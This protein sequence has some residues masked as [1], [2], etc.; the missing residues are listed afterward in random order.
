MIDF[1]SYSWIATLLVT[2]TATFLLLSVDWRWNSLVLAAQYVGVLFLVA[3]HWPLAMAVTKLVAGWM[4]VAVLGMATVTIPDNQV[5]LTSGRITVAPP[6]NLTLNPLL[7]LFG[8]KSFYIFTCSMV[9]I[10]IVSQAPHFAVWIP[11]IQPEQTWSGLV[12]I[13][14]G[15]LKTGFTDRPFPTIIGLLSALSGFEVLYANIQNSLLMA[16]LLSGVT[17]VLALV[18]AYLLIS[19]QMETTS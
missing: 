11:G 3:V 2:L 13:A 4:A 9:L 1:N 10:A 19:L 12:M 5:D 14:F 16:G 7:R 18:G 6:E 17:L 8:E 15:L